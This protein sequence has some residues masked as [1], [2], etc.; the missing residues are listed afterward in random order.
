M[1]LARD[2]RAGVTLAEYW[3]RRGDEAALRR[4]MEVLLRTGLWLA[5]WLAEQGRRDEGCRCDCAGRQCARRRASPGGSPGNAAA[6]GQPEPF[7]MSG[8]ESDAVRAASERRRPEC[9]PIAHRLRDHYPERWVRFHSLPGSKRFADT[10]DEYA[11]T[12]DRHNTVLTESAPGASLLVITCE[13]TDQDVPRP[14]APGV[15]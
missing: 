13:W 1:A 7:L 5:G 10:A 11:T 15:P 8:P 2:E 14:P 12:L 4:E 9:P 3:T 6:L